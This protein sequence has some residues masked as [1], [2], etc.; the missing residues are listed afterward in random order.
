[1]ARSVACL[2]AYWSYCDGF[3]HVDRCIHALYRTKREDQLIQSDVSNTTIFN[4]FDTRFAAISS[5]ASLFSMV[6]CYPLF[7]N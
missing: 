7:Q 5:A 6:I 1:M 4:G 2:S 3:F